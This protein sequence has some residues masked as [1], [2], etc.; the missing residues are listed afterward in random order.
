MTWVASVEVRASTPDNSAGTAY[1]A[2]RTTNNFATW[3][4][5]LTIPDPSYTKVV[6]RVTD[7]SGNRIW[8]SVPVIVTAEGPPD[9]TLRVR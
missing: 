5:S 3:S 4:Y 1:A 7:T 8:L 6:V 2:A 9:I